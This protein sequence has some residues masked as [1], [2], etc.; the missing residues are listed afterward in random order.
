M[1]YFLAPLATAFALV[2]SS[3]YALIRRDRRLGHPYRDWR[4]CESADAVLSPG[5]GSA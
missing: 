5:G 1:L 2:A 3:T 4:P